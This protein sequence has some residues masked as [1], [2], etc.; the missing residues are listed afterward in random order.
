[1]SC[2]IEDATHYDKR[3]EYC[4]RYRETTVPVPPAR[5][6]GGGVL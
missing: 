5:A 4:A 1:M 6:T 3:A 2:C